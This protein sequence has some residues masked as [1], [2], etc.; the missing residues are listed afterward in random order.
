MVEW[1]KNI[2][3]PLY[4]AVILYV[5]DLFHRRLIRKI[6]K[7]GY[8]NVVFFAANLP[9]WRYQGV[10]DLMSRDPRFRVSILLTPLSTFSDE[11]KKECIKTL[12]SYFVSKSIPFE[13]TTEWTKK[14]FTN[15]KR[16]NPDILFYTQ[17]YG[18]S[19]G[20]ALDSVHFIDKLLCFAPYGVGT[21]AAEWSVNTVFQNVAWR[22][23]YETEVYHNVAKQVAYNHGIN[24]VVVGNTNADEFL[25][26]G[27]KYHWKDQAIVKKK[28][29]WAP[30]FTVAQNQMFNRSSF[31][32]LSESMLEI[33]Q[34]YKDL[35]QFVFKPH[36]RLRTVLYGL[37]D[38][39]KTRTDKYFE[40]WD[41]MPN[42]QF[43]NSSYIGLFMTSDAL[44][45]DCASFTVEYHYSKKP[46][47]FTARDIEC[48]REPLNELGRAALD[49][50]YFAHTESEIRQ[51]IDHV[52][53]DGEDT[54]KE[55]R[56]QFF[57]KYL[58]PPNGKTVAFNIYDN[59]VDSIWK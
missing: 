26:S 46:C 49:A 12:R 33:A 36:P 37:S 31:L 18:S 23:F 20:N 59:I 44:I 22:L 48:I 40:A 1:V 5:I 21:V 51:F 2:L 34:E 50:H 54:K 10:Y 17:P 28:V 24:V 38:W 13:D 43:E 14:Q 3:R 39:G 58:L 9:M 56:E 15:W 35:I 41:L 16:L 6:R 25:K 53:L 19:Y 52:V 29:I 57:Q 11:E 42:T 4:W 55:D 8:V 32:W 45:H 27:Q 47:L 30:H 7:R